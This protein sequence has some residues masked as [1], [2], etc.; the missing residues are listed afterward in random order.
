MSQP[1]GSLM[2]TGDAV[3]SRYC[4]I[5]LQNGNGNASQKPVKAARV[6]P[7]SIEVVGQS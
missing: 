2:A 3:Q 5:A 4:S 7:M 1:Y 6:P